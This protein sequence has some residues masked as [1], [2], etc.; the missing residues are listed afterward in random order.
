[1][2]RA[3]LQVI[4]ALYANHG[5][6]AAVL[7]GAFAIAGAAF[8]QTPGGAA[9]PAA[10]DAKRG[11]QIA[12]EVCAACHGPDGNSPLPANP[13]VAGQHAGY[14]AK[15]L[16]DFKPQEGAEQPARPSPIMQGFA[17]MLSADDV[18]NV[19]AWFASQPLKPSA[20]GDKA[21][22]EL[23]RD[24][25]RAGI[26]AKGVPACS[27]CHSPN[28]AG[29]PV[30]YPRVQGQY[31]EYSEAQLVAFRQ[32]TRANSEQMK[33][34]AERLSDREIKAVSEYMAGLR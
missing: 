1:M 13:I 25:Y 34:I 8:A 33:T 12:Q 6:R 10:V 4:P 9:Q 18:R 28:G 20:A 30:Q 11:S 14:L 7:F 32:G 26:A 5:R 29:I 17:A 31:A 23:G 19:S 27:G 22:A 3:S 16:N 24:I 21:L 15:Q 2:L